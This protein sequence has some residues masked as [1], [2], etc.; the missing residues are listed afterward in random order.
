MDCRLE[1]VVGRDDTLEGVDV[2]EVVLEEDVCGLLFGVG[3]GFA[4]VV[5]VDSG[6]GGLGRVIWL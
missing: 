3:F 5:V 6:F 1:D 4:G 2:L